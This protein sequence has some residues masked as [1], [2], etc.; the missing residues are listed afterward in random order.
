MQA[1]KQRA[2]QQFGS[3]WVWLAVDR[4]DYDVGP[5]D[6]EALVIIALPNQVPHCLMQ[7]IRA[8]A[9]AASSFRAAHG[10]H[11]FL[12]LRSDRSPLAVRG[13]VYGRSSTKHALVLPDL[14]TAVIQGYGPVAQQR[15]GRAVL[16][17]ARRVQHL[18]S[19]VWLEEM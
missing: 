7:T 17:D 3:G 9:L 12:F 6:P 1:F 2:Q 16:P 5:K 18:I 4:S 8:P 14:D 13:I 11:P 10:Q 15:C 19:P